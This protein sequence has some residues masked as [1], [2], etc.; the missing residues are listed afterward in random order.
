LI[1]KIIIIGAST[2]G[3]VQIKEI[4]SQ[5]QT[6]NAIIIVAQHMKEDVLPFFI[7]DIKESVPF[8]VFSTPTPIDFTK[9]AIIVCAATSIF[10]NN[11]LLIDRDGQNY[12]PDI[13]KL[14]YSF[15]MYA[16]RYEIE[17]FI[18][19]GIGAD[20]V[21]GAASLKNHGA[22]VYVADEQSSAVYGMPRIAME[23]GIADK[24]LSLEAMKAYFR[25][26]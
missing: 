9:P 14:L 17:I 23:R 2:G 5:I 8:D 19:T 7:K 3:P 26:I 18:L 13:D 11:S 6:L 21:A 22:K 15:E 1:K 25:N 20:G 4:L 10:K 24:S 12:T 16:N